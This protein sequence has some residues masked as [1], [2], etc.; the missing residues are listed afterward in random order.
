VLRVDLRA[1]PDDVDERHRVAT[2]E[3]VFL[4]QPVDDDARLGAV[5]VIPF[6]PG[7]LDELAWGEPG[8]VLDVVEIDLERYRRSFTER[9]R[10]ARVPSTGVG[11]LVR[12]CQTLA[13]TRSGHLD[14]SVR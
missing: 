10:V 7:L 12:Q 4:F 3:P 6:L 2:A 11:T 1:V 8:L 5:L 13:V 9:G 14:V